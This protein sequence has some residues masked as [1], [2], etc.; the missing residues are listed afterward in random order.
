M[1]P[2]LSRFHG[3]TH[4]MFCQLLYG[5]HWMTGAA[6]TTG[7]TTE[8]SNS[9]MSRYGSTTKHMSNSNRRDHLTDGMI[10]W[11]QEKE[12]GMAKQL[13]KFYNAALDDSTRHD[14][15]F[16]KQKQKWL[17][18]IRYQLSAAREKLLV[19]RQTMDEIPF[20]LKKLLQIKSPT[21]KLRDFALVQS[22]KLRAAESIIPLLQSAIVILEKSIDEGVVAQLPKILE[23]LRNEAS[24]CHRK[25]ITKKN[26]FGYC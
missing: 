21:Q 15:E 26:T 20:K 8:Q 9:K 14:K 4:T 1:V 12:C 17:E 2:F 11:N 25:R 23:Q 5:G 6:S 13:A 7:E 10:Y 24:H 19:A 18:E 3:K 22:N 16:E